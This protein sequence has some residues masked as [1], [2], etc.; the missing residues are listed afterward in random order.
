MPL[1][2]KASQMSLPPSPNEPPAPV[3]LIAHMRPALVRYFRRK[4]DSAAETEDLVQ[5]VLMR[6]LTHAEWKSPAE[7]R[8]YIFRIAVNLWRDLCRR[9]RTHGI[10]VAWDEDTSAEAGV[11]NPPE[12]VL[13]MREELEQLDR[14]LREL[15]VRTRT[16]LVLVK[17][18]KMRIATVAQMLGISVSAVNKHLARGLAHLA[19]IR[20]RQESP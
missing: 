2:A 14:G 15:S 12:R 16:V 5:E 10:T 9:R 6:A 19:L 7:G 11:E 18:E 3:D 8:G 17:L 4:T 1:D 20:S 13:M